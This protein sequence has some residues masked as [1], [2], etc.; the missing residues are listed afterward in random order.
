V[1]KETVAFDITMLFLGIRNAVSERSVPLCPYKCLIVLDTSFM[2]EDMQIGVLCQTEF[3]FAVPEHMMT[4]SET[5]AIS[6]QM[7]AVSGT[8]K[9]EKSSIVKRTFLDR[10]CT[11]QMTSAEGTVCLL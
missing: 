8:A 5:D 2:G 7:Y 11:V 4:V 6:R 9:T 3:Y 1:S 10:W